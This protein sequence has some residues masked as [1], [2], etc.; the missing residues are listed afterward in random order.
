M[1]ILPTPAGQLPWPAHWLVNKV[2]N[3]QEIVTRAL[4]CGTTNECRLHSRGMA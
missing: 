3:S 4:E 2:T 1:A